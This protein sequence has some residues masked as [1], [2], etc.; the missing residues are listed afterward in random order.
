MCFEPKLLEL[1]KDIQADT[2]RPQARLKKY[3]GY[4]WLEVSAELSRKL[5]THLL[6]P[7]FRIE[8]YRPG[9]YQP[10]VIPRALLEGMASRY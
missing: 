3:H 1:Y 6:N 8:G 5:Q 2:H 9:T 7:S 10:T 4:R